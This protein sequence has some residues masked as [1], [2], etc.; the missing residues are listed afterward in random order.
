LLILTSCSKGTT[1]ESQAGKQQAEEAEENLLLKNTLIVGSDTSFPPFSF[2]EDG[3]P[4]GFDID[5]INEILSKIDRQAEIIE[6]KWDP[7][8][9]NF[10]E[11]P[12]DLMVSAVL[13]DEKKEP[14]VD[15]SDPYFKM[16]YML[17]A[18]VGSDLK[19]EKDLTGKL[20]GTLNNGDLLVDE[21]W[22]FNFNLKEFDNISVMLDALKNKE[23]EGIIIS[24]P[25]AVNLLRENL[26]SYSFLAEVESA[27]QFVIV[28]KEG[29]PLKALI[30]PV[31]NELT[32]SARYAEIF[33]KWFA[34]NSL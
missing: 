30:D 32:G 7:E 21:D 26:D 27:K 19:E 29:S 5:I 33:D 17:L 34:Y 11:S 28:F 24:L 6:V 10:K 25:L 14:L 1:G 8:F 15:F 23:I 13:F 31:I 2:V 9:E 16:K 3:V 4:A 20:V 12:A 18:L 22:L